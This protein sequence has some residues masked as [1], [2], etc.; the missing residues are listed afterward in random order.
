[1]LGYICIVT[2]KV[3]ESLL[4]ESC[5]LSS[6]MALLMAVLRGDQL[7]QPTR[8]PLGNC[9]RC[10]I[11]SIRIYVP[12]DRYTSKRNM[13]FIYYVRRDDETF[14]VVRRYVKVFGT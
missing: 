13:W 2:V 14:T 10:L 5:L 8:S 12:L 3:N 6:M 11:P 9:S 7:S 4:T 1:M